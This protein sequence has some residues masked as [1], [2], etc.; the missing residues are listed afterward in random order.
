MVVKTTTPQRPCFGITLL[1]SRYVDYFR[2]MFIKL[3]YMY[4][5]VGYLAL[6]GMFTLLCV[7]YCIALWVL[8]Y[9]E[10]PPRVGCP[11]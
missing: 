9:P 2:N 1:P 8:S 4:V 6:L 7:Q 3:V 10:C 11:S 5:R